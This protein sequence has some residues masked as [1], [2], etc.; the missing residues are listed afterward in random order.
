MRMARSRNTSSSLWWYFSTILA[1]DSAS[2]RACAGSYTPQ[3]RSQWAWTTRVGRI[4][5]PKRSA[6]MRIVPFRC[7]VS[8]RRYYHPSFRRTP[9]RE[10]I[11]VMRRTAAL[12]AGALVLGGLAAAVA[13]RRARLEPMLVQG[14]SMAPTLGPGQRIAV[15]PL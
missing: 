2:I 12:G 6:I 13:V 7:D 9:P 5:A 4:H 3:G 11:G 10:I 14:A 1:I 15:A 8:A